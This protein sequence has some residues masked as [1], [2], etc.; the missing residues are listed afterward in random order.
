MII[1]LISGVVET[2]I[3]VRRGKWGFNG[4]Q[5]SL[6]VYSV[7]GEYLVGFIGFQWEMCGLVGFV[8]V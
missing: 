1:V 8:G 6:V 3:A 5:L 4:V 2:A 7:T